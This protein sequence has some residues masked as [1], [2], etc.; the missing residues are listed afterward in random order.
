MNSVSGIRTTIKSPQLTDRINGRSFVTLG[1]GSRFWK[2]FLWIKEI[3]VLVSIRYLNLTVWILTKHSFFLIFILFC[4]FFQFVFLIKTV[5]RLFPLLA[6]WRKERLSFPDPYFYSQF[7]TLPL[8]MT[9]FSAFPTSTGKLL[10]YR[11]IYYTILTQKK[12]INGLNIFNPTI[13]RK[14][15]KFSTLMTML[16]SIVI[17]LHRC[18]ISSLMWSGCFSFCLWSGILP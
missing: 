6:S 8:D 10:L 18:Y 16:M 17:H 9:Y 3:S 7:W 5:P 15:T 11:T 1:L 14:V 2:I 13:L 4:E 12:F